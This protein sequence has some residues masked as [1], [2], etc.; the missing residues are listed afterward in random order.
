[1]SAGTCRTR[2]GP[3]RKI[4]CGALDREPAAAPQQQSGTSRRNGGF[5]LQIYVS[6]AG[7]PFSRL[8][9]AGPGWSVTAMSRSEPPGNLSRRRTFDQGR[10]QFDHPSG[11]L[12]QLRA[13]PAHRGAARR[14]R[15]HRT[16]VRRQG[17]G[18]R[19]E[20][21]SIGRTNDRDSFA[22]V[23]G[24]ACSIRQGNVFGVVAVALARCTP[25]ARSSRG[26]DE[27][28]SLLEGW[29]ERLGSAA[30]LAERPPHPD[31]I[32]RCDIA[33]ASLRRFEGRPPKAA[34]ASL[35]ERGEVRVY[36]APPSG[37][38]TSRRATA[39]FATDSAA[40]MT[41]ILSIGPFKTGQYA[42]PIRPPR[43]RTGR[44]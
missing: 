30:G 3:G 9:A 21:V 7:R 20:S 33:E 8:T 1:M 34:H 6:G 35:H 26:E 15:L 4:G 32:L 17:V 29:D 11:Q 41:K 25:S 12:R 24:I 40:S 23:S 44:L 13:Q 16:D 2:G 43:I 18:I 39:R 38:G 27:R 10:R 42:T 37:T 5:E 28:R 19:A 31:R 14:G 36:P 22:S